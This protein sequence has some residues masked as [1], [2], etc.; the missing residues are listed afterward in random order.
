[1]LDWT[2]VYVAETVTNSEIIIRKVSE[3]D[4]E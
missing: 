3:M 1:M 2:G 4:S